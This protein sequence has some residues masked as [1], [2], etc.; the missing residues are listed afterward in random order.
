LIQSEISDL[1]LCNREGTEAKIEE[2]AELGLLVYKSDAGRREIQL[3]DSLNKWNILG[4]Y[5]GRV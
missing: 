2:L 3:K 1:L 4:R 5:Y